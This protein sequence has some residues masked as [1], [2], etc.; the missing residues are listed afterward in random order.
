MSPT[1][2]PTR[3][4]HVRKH[5]LGTYGAPTTPQFGRLRAPDQSS[6]GLPLARGKAGGAVLPS[7][8]GICSRT[9]ARSA[10]LGSGTQAREE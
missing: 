8:S 10:A 7:R 3:T 4:P 5:S 9:T 6:A 1:W 2:A